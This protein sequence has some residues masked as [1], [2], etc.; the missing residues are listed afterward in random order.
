MQVKECK[1]KECKVIRTSQLYIYIYIY[2]TLKWFRKF[3][4][5]RLILVNS[6]I[7]NF[8]MVFVSIVVK[9]TKNEEE[10]HILYLL[11]L[12]FQL[13]IIS[14]IKF[15]KNNLINSFNINN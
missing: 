13:K 8:L 11:L 1:V 12:L 14:Y 4:G 3:K 2:I 5:L 10:F 7:F 6:K 15:I 9:T